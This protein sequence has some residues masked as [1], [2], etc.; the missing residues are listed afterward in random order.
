MVEE[1]DLDAVLARRPEVAVLDEFAH[2]NAPGS[3]HAKRWQDAEELLQAGIDVV[4]TVDV[5]QLDS[6]CDVVEK[7]TG[8]PPGQTV[9]DAFVRAADEVEIVDTAPKT[10]RDRMAHGDIYPAEE[11]AAALASW[12]RIGHLSALRELALL[13]LAAM[14]AGDRHRH[15]PGGPLPGAPQA[16]ERVVVALTDNS[17]GEGLIRRAARLAA[18]SG[19]D[20][21]A[22][23]VARPGGPAGSGHAALTTQPQLVRSVGGTYH[24]LSDND[25]SAALLIF[26]QAENATQLVLGATRRSWRSALLPRATT[27]SRVLRGATGIDV[28]FVTCT[29][30]ATDNPPT[31]PVAESRE[32]SSDDRAEWVGHVHVSRT[33]SRVRALV[34]TG[35]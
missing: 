25:I 21:L 5:R 27:R 19:G 20:L 14:L 29:Q 10:L 2:S 12:F 16:R 30:I 31:A 18:R 33:R 6:L 24:Q 28:H 32:E 22:V 26:A 13:W 8:G 34:G 7:I 35:T 11:A 9:P 23:H 3:R 17:D 1:L 4:S 15:R